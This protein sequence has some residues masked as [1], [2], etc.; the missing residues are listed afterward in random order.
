MDV[1]GTK[2]SKNGCA[3][4]LANNKS[5]KC[6]VKAISG[7][8]VYKWSITI[9]SARNVPR[10]SLQSVKKTNK[11][12]T[13]SIKY[14]NKS[15]EWTYYGYYWKV[16]RID[17]G[18]WIDISEISSYDDVEIGVAANHSH[19]RKINVAKK[20]ISLFTK[21]VYRVVTNYCVNNRFKYTYFR[22][23]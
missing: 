11:K 13:I 10:V 20:N 9:K 19:K 22:I 7:N 3:V 23:E 2:G 16:Q 18:K 6:T 15:D 21:G 17:N 14:I 4:V 5:G 12:L 8:K 1:I